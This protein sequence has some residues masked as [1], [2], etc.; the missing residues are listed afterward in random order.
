MKNKKT[1]RLKLT[2]ENLFNPI[3]NKDYGLYWYVS[4]NKKEPL[5][6][7]E[8]LLKYVRRSSTNG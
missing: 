1:D 5:A 3:N 2:L 7:A 6:N 8:E 4:N